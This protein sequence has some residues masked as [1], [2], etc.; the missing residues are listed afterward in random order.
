MKLLEKIKKLIRNSNPLIQK[1]SFIDKCLSGKCYKIKE[2]LDALL[3]A[4]ALDEDLKKELGM[5][6]EEFEQ[7]I[8]AEENYF[9]VFQ[10]ILLNRVVKK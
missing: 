5:T 4:N 7:F 9:D 3:Q 10:K 6:D 8:S 1:Q 2:N